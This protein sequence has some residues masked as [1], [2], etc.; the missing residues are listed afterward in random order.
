MI[1]L[2]LLLL[3]TAA[4]A[5]DNYEIQVYGSDL[6]APNQTMVELHSNIAFS[7]SQIQ[8]EGVRPADHAF[9]ET[10]EVTHGFN[11]WM[12]VGVY[13]FNSLGSDDRTTYV[14]S[15]LRP[16]FAVP[17]SFN[18]PVGVS[19]SL[20]AGYQKRE[21]SED[22]WTLEIR[23][24]IDKQWGKWYFAFNPTFDHALHGY[25]SG[26]G[27]NFSPNLKI[28]FSFSA[29]LASGIEYY[30]SVGPLTAPQS[31]SN[32]QQQVFVVSDLNVSPFWEL[33]MGYG[34]G[35]T[36]STVSPILKWI[37]GYRF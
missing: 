16:R 15:H 4:R 29:W 34:I 36:E 37:V 32:Q 35:F 23:P 20:E 13:F 6:V 21:Y 25:N 5:Q 8:A 28:N 10:I 19:L 3:S 27:F 14:G 33:N 7:N 17:P 24:I 31:W 26:N 30:G 9:H 2:V 22:D 12:E 11:S 1:S 18:W